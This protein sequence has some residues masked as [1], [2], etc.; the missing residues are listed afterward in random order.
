MQFSPQNAPQCLTKWYDLICTLMIAV[1]HNVQIQKQWHCTKRW[2]HCNASQ[3]CGEFWQ[4]SHCEFK[5]T[6]PGNLCGDNQGIFLYWN[7]LIHGLKLLWSLQLQK[8]LTFVVLRP[9]KIDIDCKTAKSSLCKWKIRLFFLTHNSNLFPL[10]LVHEASIIHYIVA[11]ILSKM[12]ARSSMCGTQLCIGRNG[13][14]GLR[15]Q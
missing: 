12:S 13:V 14:R 4:G 9:K 2:N 7:N 11:I 10:Y 8:W 15:I 1:Q 3:H 6:R 5:Q